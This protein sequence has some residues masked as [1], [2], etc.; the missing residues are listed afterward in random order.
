MKEKIIIMLDWN[1]GPIWGN[2][3]DPETFEKSTGVEIVD[4][5]KTVQELNN[6]I[7]ELYSSYYDFDSN[8][9]GCT[10][11]KEKEIADKTIMLD[12]LG[13]LISRLNELNDGSFE[14]EDRESERIKNL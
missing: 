9:E 11:N 5:D 2:Y 7:S 4:N 8:G 12:L 13:K 10:F 1:A 6:K 14:I 3:I